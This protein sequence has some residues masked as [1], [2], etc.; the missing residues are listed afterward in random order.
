MYKMYALIGQSASGKDTI[1]NE[2]LKRYGDIFHGV[3]SHTTRPKRD[4]E[5]NHKD[6]HFVSEEEMIDL[7]KSGKIL[8]AAV[9]NSWIY[10]TSIESL[11]E[12]KI[13]LGVFNIEGIYSLLEEE[14]DIDLRVFYVQVKDKLRLIRQLSRENDPDI[15]EILRRYNTDAADFVEYN[16]TFPYTAIENNTSDDFENCIATI[17]AFSEED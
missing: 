6:Y 15:K 12:D 3:V 7:M 11:S 16:I 2:L 17:K 4:Y 1:V 9:F 5:I 13:N 14:E 10:G 8:E